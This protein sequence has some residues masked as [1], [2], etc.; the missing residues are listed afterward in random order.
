MQST[1]LVLEILPPMAEHVVAGLTLQE[2]KDAT[3]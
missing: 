2:F 1:P 3:Q